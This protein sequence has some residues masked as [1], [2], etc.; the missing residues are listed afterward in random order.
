MSAP[1]LGKRKG[2]VWLDELSTTGLDQGLGVGPPEND[3]VAILAVHA[4]IGVGA[5]T[6]HLG[7]AQEADKDGGVE[8][9]GVD[10]ADVAGSV[11]QILK[12]GG[13]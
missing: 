7:V 12:R 3:D 4:A 5:T 1:D 9:G 8:V 11:V 6:L 2:L 10:H 13:E